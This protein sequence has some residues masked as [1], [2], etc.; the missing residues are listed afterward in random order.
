MI[1][2]DDRIGSKELYP[3]FPQGSA[4]LTHLAYGDFMF[5]GHYVDSDIAIGIERKRIGDFINSMV[6]GRFMGHQLIGMQNSY[7]YNYLILEGDFRAHPKTGILEMNSWA[8]WQ[9][10]RAGKQQFMARD[11]WAFMNTIEVM[12]GVHCYHCTYPEDTVFYLVALHHWWR[13]EFAEHKGHLQPHV[14][15][16]KVQLSRPSLVRKVASQFDGIGWDR[17]KGIDKQFSTVSEFVAA[18]FSE[19]IEIDGIGKGLA[20]SIVEQRGGGK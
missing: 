4:K 17:A 19:L 7:H 6:S 1:Y 11:I 10:Y 16:G 14:V 18:D 15:T 3:M 13:K 9:P 12:C 8:G 20:S 5:A 2:V